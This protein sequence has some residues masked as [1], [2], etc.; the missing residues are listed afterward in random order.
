MT[1]HPDQ[2]S[3]AGFRHRQHGQLPRAP[4]KG[5]LPHI[6][7]K[8]LMTI[9]CCFFLNVYKLNKNATF[10][11]NMGPPILSFS[12]KIDIRNSCGFRPWITQIS[13]LFEFINFKKVGKS[14]VVIERPKT[15][16]SSASG[17][18]APSS[19]DQEFCPWRLQSSKGFAP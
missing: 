13:A 9:F 19:P 14:A 6:S 16:S 15:K 7:R 8:K 3:R 11:N 18:F 17:N 2:L 1:N 12:L 10:R 5:G 4:Q